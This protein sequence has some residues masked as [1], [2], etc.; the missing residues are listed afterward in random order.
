MKNITIDLLRHGDA[1][2]GKKLLGM[3]DEPLTTLGWQQMRSIFSSKNISWNK[4]V[5]SP[6]QRC[7][8]FSEELSQRLS[9][10]FSID[11]RF[12]EINFGR[13]DG[14]L[15]T[16]IYKSEESEHLNQFRQDPTSV[17]PP[18]GEAY[19]DFELRV[20]TAWQELLHSL[21]K[22]QIEHCLLVTHGGVIRTI[23][24]QVLGFPATNMFQLEVPYACLSRIKQYD[25]Y[26]ATLSFHGGNL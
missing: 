9:L 1:A 24:S 12:Q 11:N 23:I 13:W 15:L 26:P 21:Y 3:T 10:P 16:D 18:G 7:S 4:V 17:L 25:G 14:Q 8:A 19:K 2:G 20:M 22:E 5:S 6:L